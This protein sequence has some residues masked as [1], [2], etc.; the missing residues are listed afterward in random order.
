[1]AYRNDPRVDPVGFGQVPEHLRQVRD[2]GLRTLERCVRDGELSSE[3]AGRMDTLVRKDDPLTLGAR[4]LAAVGDPVYAQAFGKIL[5]DPQHAHLRMSREEQTAVQQV[6]QAEEARAMAGGTGST[7]G[8]GLPI[9]IDPTINLLGA[10]AL[11]PVRQYATVRTMESLTLRLVSADQVTA[12]YLAEAA[13]ATDNSPTLAQPTITAARGTAFI[14]FSIE[15]GQDYPDLLNELGEILGDARANLDSVQFLTGTGTNAPQG[16]L[17]GLSSATWRQQTATVAVTAIADGYALKNALPARHLPNA[18]FAAHPSVWD[19]FFRFVGG[20][21]AEPPLIGP[22]LGARDGKFLGYPKFEWTAMATTTTT[23]T[24]TGTKIMIGGDWKQG[25][26]IADRIGAQLELI[27]HIFGASQGNLP[28]GQRVRS[29]TGAP[30][31]PSSPSQPTR[32]SDGW[33]SSN[34]GR[35]ASSESHGANRIHLPGER[36]AASVPTGAACA[37]RPSRGEGAPRAVREGN[38]TRVSG[39]WATRPQRA[40]PKGHLVNPCAT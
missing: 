14:P 11:N 34:D 37:G 16:V 39:V 22:S 17:T 2:K 13:P 7:G 35:K 36:R 27:P 23:T 21:S 40:L 26:V 32:R 25:F 18:V 31:R 24:T 12:G 5:K 6:V 3:A 29:S 28:T 30:A 38:V 19:V 33:R 15:V 9:Q 8:F 4:Y 1:L 20:G 10:G